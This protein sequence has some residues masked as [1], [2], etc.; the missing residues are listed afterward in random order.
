ME[1]VPVLKEA[2][3]QRVVCGPITYSPDILPMVGPV[4]GRANYWC[5]VGFGYG[6]AHAGGVGRSVDMIFQQFVWLHRRKIVKKTFSLTAIKQQK[7]R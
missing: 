1:T 5:A 7:S 6:I 3:I 4:R 2:E